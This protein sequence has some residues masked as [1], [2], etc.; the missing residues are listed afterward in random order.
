MT[1]NPFSQ[2]LAYLA[3]LA[4]KERDSRLLLHATMTELREQGC[5][6]REIAAAAKMSHET[7]RRLTS[8]NN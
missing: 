7:V 1:D 2:S 8:G 3:I 6:L 4:K 5:S